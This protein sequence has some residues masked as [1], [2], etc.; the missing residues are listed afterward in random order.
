MRRTFE[1]NYKEESQCQLN[2]I[3]RFRIEIQKKEEK[4]DMVIQKTK[5][6]VDFHHKEMAEEQ[7]RKLEKVHAKLHG[8]KEIEEMNGLNEIIKNACKT[9][10]VK[11]K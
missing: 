9:L 6:A 11:K 5:E 3:E 4:G 7:K 10:I 8:L 1:Q 2:Q